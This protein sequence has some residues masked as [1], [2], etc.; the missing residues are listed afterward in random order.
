MSFRKNV[1]SILP[2][3]TSV[4]S[5]KSGTHPEFG[6]YTDTTR[7]YRYI[8]ETMAKGGIVPHLKWFLPNYGEYAF[9]DKLYVTPKK[10][11]S[12]DGIVYELFLESDIDNK[13]PILADIEDFEKLSQEAE[14]KILTKVVFQN[15]PK[16]FCNG[17]NDFYSQKSNVKLAIDGYD[18]TYDMSITKDKLNDL[19]KNSEEKLK[20]YELLKAEADK[21]NS[22]RDRAKAEFESDSENI[23]KH[24]KFK[25]LSNIASIKSKKAE[26]AKE[27]SVNSQNAVDSFSQTMD[28]YSESPSLFAIFEWQQKNMPTG[29]YIFDGV[30]VTESPETS[31]KFYAWEYVDTTETNG[32]NFRRVP[33]KSK[34]VYTTTEFG[35]KYSGVSVYV[36]QGDDMK[37]ISYSHTPDGAMTKILKTITHF[38]ISANVLTETTETYFTD[39]VVTNKTQYFRKESSDKDIKVPAS[40]QNMA[41]IIFVRPY[42]KDS[43][44]TDV[45]KEFYLSQNDIEKLKKIDFD[46]SF[47]GSLKSYVEFPYKVEGSNK[48]YFITGYNNHFGYLLETKDNTLS[49]KKIFTPEDVDSIEKN[50]VYVQTQDELFELYISKNPKVISALFEDLDIPKKYTKIGSTIEDKATRE[51]FQITSIS[52]TPIEAKIVLSSTRKNG[53]KN[54]E[55]TLEEFKKE[56]IAI[57]PEAIARKKLLWKLEKSVASVAKVSGQKIANK[58]WVIPGYGVVSFLSGDDESAKVISE[59]KKMLYVSY[60]YFTNYIMFLEENLVNRASL[61]YGESLDVLL[62][63]AN[64]RLDSYLVYSDITSNV[65]IVLRYDTTDKKNNIITQ[66][67]VCTIEDIVSQDSELKIVFKRLSDKKNILLSKDEMDLSDA[68]IERGKNIDVFAKFSGIPKE[69][70]SLSK[71]CGIFFKGKKESFIIDS[72]D[73]INK[74][75]E[76]SQTNGS[77]EIKPMPVKKFISKVEEEPLNK[78]IIDFFGEDMSVNS[79]EL[80]VVKKYLTKS[81]FKVEFYD[82]DFFVSDFVVARN[83][84]KKI[85]LQSKKEG[86]VLNKTIEEYSDILEYNNL[87]NSCAAKRIEIAMKKFDINPDFAQKSFYIVGEPVKYEIVDIEDFTTIKDNESAAKSARVVMHWVLPTSVVPIEAKENYFLTVEQFKQKATFDEPSSYF[88]KKQQQTQPKDGYNSARTDKDVEDYIASKFLVNSDIHP[89]VWETRM[90]VLIDDDLFI[91]N[92][93]NPTEGTLELVNA[94]KE[95]DARNADDKIVV[96]A[97][98]YIDKIIFGIEEN[99]ISYEEHLK[100]WVDLQE[101]GELFSYLEEKEKDLAKEHNT[102]VDDAIQIPEVQLAL[103]KGLLDGIRNINGNQDVK[104]GSYLYTMR[105]KKSPSYKTQKATT[106]TYDKDTVKS[107][108]DGKHEPALAQTPDEWFERYNIDTKYLKEPIKILGNDYFFSDVER[109]N[110]N[111]VRG[112]VHFVFKPEIP[113]EILNNPFLANSADVKKAYASKKIA[114]GELLKIISKMNQ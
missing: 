39:E 106:I 110:Y 52:I 77:T 35:E 34:T 90:P 89:A 43:H 59:D 83:K 64:T 72:I 101:L 2:M 100:D 37:E 61:F 105:K 54:K 30:F 32:R 1:E 74:T 11:S 19:E 12:K 86:I 97:D 20:N 17:A 46:T 62:D 23:V 76:I 4:I 53:G 91:I 38:N 108:D 98:E 104:P 9:V 45:G 24:E 66:E 26:T 7:V 75:V 78:K 33:N 42:G 56:F 84:K 6:K 41:K 107:A 29:W 44:S 57:S 87:F 3:Q 70:C 114:P 5:E 47:D 92:K 96:S 31:K 48:E 13:N 60:D 95:K 71:F 81:E 73:P 69:Y 82:G 111:D 25:N 85:K 40:R 79:N 8:I 68:K 55:L 21:W 112:P 49:R 113:K 22:L 14:N 28:A 99:R 50:R 27:E 18:E 51:K 16:W 80:D 63:D 58:H 15:M 93:V 10:G 109:P 65:P 94:T 36:N 88:W 102:T 103:R 67:V